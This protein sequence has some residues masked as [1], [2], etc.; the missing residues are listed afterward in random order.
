MF[1]YTK[2][3][4]RSTLRGLN[5]FAVFHRA[6]VGPEAFVTVVKVIHFAPRMPFI[7]HK[8][9]HIESLYFGRLLFGQAACCMS[10]Q[11]L[12]CFVLFFLGYPQRAVLR[13][14]DLLHGHLVLN[15]VVGAGLWFR[16]Q[17]N[18]IPVGHVLKG[19]KRQG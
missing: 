12:C 6:S 9:G 15:W 11:M 4:N 2:A 7:V 10:P 3:L 18:K 8:G 17:P 19:R 14:E 1:S 13:E 5:L 16:L